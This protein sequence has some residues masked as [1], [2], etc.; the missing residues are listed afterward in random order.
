MHLLSD[1]ARSEPM[2]DPGKVVLS[3]CCCWCWL[4]G[5]GFVRIISGKGPGNYLPDTAYTESDNCR[6]QV[7]SFN[8]FLTL[9]EKRCLNLEHESWYAYK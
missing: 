7:C 5:A 1:S 8:V 3:N 2:S 6:L 9:A 4:L